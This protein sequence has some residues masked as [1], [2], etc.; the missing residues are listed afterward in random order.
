M[1][2]LIVD[3]D[4]MNLSV[5]QKTL[6]KKGYQVKAAKNGEIALGIL[7]AEKCDLIISDILMP[8]MDGYHLCQKCK[9]DE[10]LRNIPF[11][12]CSGTYTD[13][14][15]EDLALK[16]GAEV[17]ISKP[18]TQKELFGAIKKVVDDSAAGKI[19]TKAPR[20]DDEK[21]VYKLY[22]ERLIHKLEKKMHDLDNE[23]MA[24][25]MEVA[26]RIK[27]EKRLIESRDFGDNLFRSAPGI[28]LILDTEGNILRFNPFMEMVSGYSLKEVK[29]RNW[30]DVFS[31][32]NGNLRFSA[33]D[34][35]N[36]NLEVPV[37]STSSIVTKSGKRRDIMWF[38]ST[39]KNEEGK[40]I[41]L[42]AVGQDITRQI[43]TQ[44]KQFKAKKNEAINKFIEKFSKTAGEAN[45]H[46]L[47]NLSA[48]E[49]EIGKDQAKQKYL[50]EIRKAV[51]S[52]KSSIASMVEVRK[53]NIE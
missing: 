23:K 32:E 12:F 17:F 2:I 1:K 29:G 27:A 42:L 52:T 46:I 7:R 15:D 16:F 13:D 47:E 19:K 34:T 51:L 5:L 33:S 20:F 39:L 53:K 21:D 44:K 50:K 48:L 10:S 8:V 4:M 38:D 25:E 6:E 35:K 28:V 30:A 9:E 14:K 22:S 43:K 3:D 18:Y 31:P 26:E 37:G 36:N 40:V 24:L 49:K 11:I 45:N 41:G